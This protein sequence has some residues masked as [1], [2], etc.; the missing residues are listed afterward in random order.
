[1]RMIF[2]VLT[3]SSAVAAASGT[4]VNTEPDTVS[5]IKIRPSP[6]VRLL[7]IDSEIR[8]LEIRVSGGEVFQRKMN[9]LTPWLTLGSLPLMAVGALFK[10]SG[11]GVNDQVGGIVALVAAGI[12]LGVGMINVLVC[13]FAVIDHLVQEASSAEQ[14]QERISELRAER[15]QLVLRI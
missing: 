8:S 10:L 7:E 1:M 5:E 4:I 2:T 9:G 15:S 3:L 6:R 14:R 11:S 12:L 13:T